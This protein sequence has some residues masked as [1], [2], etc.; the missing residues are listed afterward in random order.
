MLL[1]LTILLATTT[2]SADPIFFNCTVSTSCSGLDV[3]H[4]SDL[5]DAHAE[6]NSQSNYQYKVCCNATGTDISVSQEISGGFI[7]LS[8]PTDAHIEAGNKTNYGYHLK[9]SSTNGTI[10]CDYLSSCSGY[11]TCLI[12]MSDY[13]DAHVGDCITNPYQIML[14]CKIEY[15]S[16][17]LNLNTTIALWNDGVNAYGK[18]IKNNLPLKSSD[19]VIKFD[20][21]VCCETK[22]D[23]DGKYNCSFTVMRNYISNVNITA[24]VTDKDTLQNKTAS[25]TL[26]VGLSYGHKYYGGSTGCYE[27]PK[28]IQ[29][30]DNSID[31][32][33]VKICVWK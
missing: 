1:I 6:L 23:D 28:L 18:A 16:L 3:F 21:E 24:T 22:T 30:P 29:N 33:I 4:I 27:T 9:F 10:I 25:T 11:N 20:D 13:T 17:T 15:M 26:K 12:S 31:I 8:Y 19:V 7:G 5:T 2:I 32:V 14:C